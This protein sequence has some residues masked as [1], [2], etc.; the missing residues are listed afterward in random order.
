MRARI[1][2]D[3]DTVNARTRPSRKDFV[4]DGPDPNTVL[5]DEDFGFSEEEDEDDDDDN[6]IGNGIGQIGWVKPKSY[7]AIY[8][9]A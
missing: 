7:A 6:V 8:C 9:C 5:T 3:S 2:P 4:A 1:A